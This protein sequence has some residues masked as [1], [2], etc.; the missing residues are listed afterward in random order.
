MRRPP[1][2]SLLLV[3]SAAHVRTPVDVLT[4]PVHYESACSSSRSDA[5]VFE[6]CT[7]GLRGVPCS[8]YI[9]D[10]FV[11]GEEVEALQQL[12]DRGL[13]YSTVPGG[14]AIMDVN[15][16]MLL[17]AHG[18]LDVYSGQNRRAQGAPPLARRLQPV[19]RGA[20]PPPPRPAGMKARFEPLALMEEERALYRSVFGRI[21]AKVR[22]VAGLEQL[23]F[24]APTFVARL[25]GDR[26]AD[27]DAPEETVW[28]PASP[29]DEYWHP[30]VDAANTAHYAWSALLYLST[31]GHDF[32]GGNFSF[33]RAA[34]GTPSASLHL[35]HDM[36][37]EGAWVDEHT[38]APRAGRLVVFS[39]GAEH[40]HVVRR[41]DAGVR[42]TISAW[43]TCD[44]SREFGEFLDGKAHTKFNGAR[45]GEGEL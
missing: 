23:F 36:S 34:N 32:V 44:P 9:E 2:L 30:H 19:R 40:P 14:P 13:A 39:A 8:T 6:C 17:D 11:S 16:G 41:V 42:T 43:F 20:T 12:F 21:A 22:V 38:V 18:M 10:G 3:A 7:P 1:L 27:V 28:V 45:T 4:A 35:S 29:H 24:T 15:A 31:Q 5:A 33:L 26:G 25:I 37:E